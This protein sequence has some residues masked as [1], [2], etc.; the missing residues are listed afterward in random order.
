MG[1]MNVIEIAV[2]SSFNGQP[3]MS[4]LPQVHIIAQAANKK[5]DALRNL[6]SVR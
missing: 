5:D 2:T 1:I 6:C 3:S 4:P